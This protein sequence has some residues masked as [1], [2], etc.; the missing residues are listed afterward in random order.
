MI[1]RH[2]SRAFLAALLLAALPLGAACQVVPPAPT[3]LPAPLTLAQALAIA[4]AHQPQQFLARTQVTQAQGQKQQAR[5]QYFPTLTPSYQY[6]NHSRSFYGIS[7][8]SVPTTTGTAIG[9]TGTG[10]GTTETGTTTGTGVGTGTTATG[11]G[12]PITTT[13]G[14]SFGGVNEVSVV[15]GGGLNVS[16]SQNLFDSGR[17]ETANAQARRAL[18]AAS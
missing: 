7:T 9:T 17:R 18:D 14:N 2:P 15:R 16:L 5:A 1:M 4:L 10:T 13:T 8:G 3:T 12:Q 6:Q 11:T